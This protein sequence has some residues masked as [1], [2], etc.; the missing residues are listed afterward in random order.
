[1]IHNKVV[2]KAAISP[3]TIRFNTSQVMLALL[4]DLE[5]QYLSLEIL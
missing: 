4:Q 5:Q 2:F 1:M 3:S